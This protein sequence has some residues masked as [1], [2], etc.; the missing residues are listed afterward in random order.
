MAQTVWIGGIMSV[1]R[2][3]SAASI[4]AIEASAESPEPKISRGVLRNRDHP[5]AG[6]TAGHSSSSEK[7]EPSGVPVDFGEGLHAADPQVSTAVLKYGR[8]VVALQAVGI[9]DI[10]LISLER[11]LPV[12]EAIQTAS[13]CADPDIALAI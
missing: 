10:V 12:V 4:V 2:E 13:G 7:C 11:R 8:G 6:R 3:T 5:R 9:V 1:N